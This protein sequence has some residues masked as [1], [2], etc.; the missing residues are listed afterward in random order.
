MRNVHVT[1]A[2]TDHNCFRK[3]L[4]Q[5]N[6]NLIKE[7]GLDPLQYILKA[8]EPSSD[9]S[10][11]LNKGNEENGEENDQETGSEES[12]NEENGNEERTSVA[13]DHI[14]VLPSHHVF[15]DDDNDNSQVENVHRGRYVIFF[16]F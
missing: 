5:F 10:S 11:S 4:Y 7:L 12:D 8:P 2:S 9:I 15:H 1:F 13:M 16:S 14:M 3:K 6:L